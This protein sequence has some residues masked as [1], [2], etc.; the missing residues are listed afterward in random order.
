MITMIRTI[1]VI[2]KWVIE[3]YKCLKSQQK[4]ISH[5]YNDQEIPIKKKINNRRWLK[6]NYNNSQTK[7]QTN[8]DYA[9]NTEQ[10]QR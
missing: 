2:L 1:N 9:Y 3:Y 10:L 4:I 6:N 5:E 7:P 8:F